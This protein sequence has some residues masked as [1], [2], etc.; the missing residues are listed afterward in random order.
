[1]QPLP[2]PS[3]AKILA[4][5]GFGNVRYGN[6]SY[7]DLAPYQEQ[8]AD[9]TA[10]S[11][12]SPESKRAYR[13]GVREFF[14]FWQGA[15]L[16]LSRG[17]VEAFR[18]DLLAK[19]VS[20][21]TVNL[22]LCAVRA[23]ASVLEAN[24]LIPTDIARAIR[25]TKGVPLRGQRQGNWLSPKQAKDLL[26]APDPKTL[27]GL[28]DRALLGVLLGTG[29]RRTEAT[30]LEVRHLK[31]LDG[32]L[33]IVDLQ[34]KGGRLRTIPLPAWVAT[35]LTQWL[36]ASGITEGKV[37]RNFRKGN[38]I[39]GT[40]LTGV[41]VDKIVKRYAKPLGIEVAP[42][43]LRRTFAKRLR[44]QGGALEQIQLVLGHANIATTQRYLGTE[45]ELENAVTD[46]A[47]Y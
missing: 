40:G 27:L 2:V 25:D 6:L 4:Q 15:G 22:R 33:C 44:K 43:D 10:N 47:T 3:G 9:L 7:A 17:L 21:S 28:R 30:L 12:L 29:L 38:R 46:L 16:P 32:R 1:M 11:V 8:I 5:I 36:T 37:F 34:G 26:E 39:A 18:A 23:M 19:G 35:R 31:T 20:A 41:A 42:H 24:G 45:L 13:V 14:A